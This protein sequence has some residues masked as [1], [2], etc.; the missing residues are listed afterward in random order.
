MTFVK[1]YKYKDLYKTSTT[2][3]TR[4]VTV[5]QRSQESEGRLDRVFNGHYRD[6]YGCQKI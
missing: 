1:Q 2:V 5:L 3:Y 4:D 6:K